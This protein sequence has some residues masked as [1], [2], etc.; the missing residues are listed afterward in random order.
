MKRY[1]FKLKFRTPVHFGNGRLGA[2]E[3]FIYADTLF[4][5]L[6]KEAIKMFGEEK[7][8]DL[9][10]YAEN[11]DFLISDLFPFSDETLFIPKPFIKIHNSQD[12]LSSKKKFRKLKFIPVGDLS[13][14]LIG[15][16]IPD[17]SK[18]ISFGKNS[19]RA[20]VKINE[21][22]DNNPFG[23]GIYT[24]NDNAGLYFIASVVPS[25]ENY[26][27]N[28]LESISYTGIGGELSSGLGKFCCTRENL[29]KEFSERI[30][31]SYKKYM[32]LSICLPENDKLD[33]AIKDA[34][35]EVVK[36]S[37]FVASETYSKNPL[38]KNNL[39]CFKSGS[40]FKNKFDGQIA[41]VSNKGNH[42]VYRYAKPF[43]L[44]IDCEDKNEQIFKL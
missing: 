37:G 40:V 29:P 33:C 8:D 15:N 39:Y 31:G 6:Y 21:D 19:V 27:F 5:A 1:I 11:G 38:R 14:F 23:V 42:P 2:S 34:S 25:I 13:N 16:Y 28:L 3:N 26:I 4:S 17:D 10:K 20:N 36:R 7:A 24:F 30:N 44:G 9:R 12:D 32:S 41:D 43:W 18:Q 35:Y 22:K